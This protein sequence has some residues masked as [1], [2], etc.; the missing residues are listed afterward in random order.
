MVLFESLNMICG[1]QDKKSASSNCS[2][3]EEVELVVGA[4]SVAI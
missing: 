2:C 4:V 1:L 3:Y